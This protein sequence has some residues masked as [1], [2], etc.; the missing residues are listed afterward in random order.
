MSNMLDAKKSDIIVAV[1]LSGTDMLMTL[2]ETVI[3]GGPWLN[4][5]SD[6]FAPLKNLITRRFNH[7]TFMYG[8]SPRHS[9]HVKTRR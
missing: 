6:P 7:V 2:P 3:D 4:S 1:A 8:P 9:H 5:K